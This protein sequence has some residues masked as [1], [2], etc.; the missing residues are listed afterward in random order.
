MVK[1]KNFVNFL[2]N[3]SRKR[4]LLEN[5]RRKVFVIFFWEAILKFSNITIQ[6]TN[7]KSLLNST[8][9]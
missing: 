9:N 1:T 4:F 5:D 8:C 2:E 6:N 3:I 7:F